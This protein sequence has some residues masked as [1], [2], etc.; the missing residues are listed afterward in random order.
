[1]DSLILRTA[2]RLLLP[3][4]LL[5]SFYILLRGHN[6]PGG[7]FVGGLIASAA[8]TL[9]VVA[10][11]VE[12]AR[13]S[14]RTPTATIVAVGLLTGLIAAALPLLGGRPFFTALWIEQP[15]PVLGKVGTPTLFDVGVYLVVLGVTMR[16]I[17]A[18]AQLEE[19][20]HE[21]GDF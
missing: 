3:L 11:N 7:G 12:E 17:F 2:T 14:I 5:L 13:R 18:M 19:S 8:Y 21:E 15:L 16:I 4:M 10:Y 20:E 6:Q 9:Y 1:M